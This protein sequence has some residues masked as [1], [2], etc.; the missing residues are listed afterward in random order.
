MLSLT[1]LHAK[2]IALVT[3]ACENTYSTYDA[4]LPSKTLEGIHRL[5][6]AA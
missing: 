6:G 1:S 3:S 5:A 2:A 4:P